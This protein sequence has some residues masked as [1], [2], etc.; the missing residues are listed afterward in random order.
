[1][2]QPTKCTQ[3]KTNKDSKQQKGRNKQGQ[4]RE[5]TWKERKE[6]KT[7]GKGGGLN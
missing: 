2:G 3:I 1:M 5:E 6:N 7:R 4:V